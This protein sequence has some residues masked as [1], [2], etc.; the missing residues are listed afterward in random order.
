M[1]RNANVSPTDPAVNGNA[2]NPGDPAESDHVSEADLSFNPAELEAAATGPD[3]F[4]PASL[5]LPRISTL[6]WAFA[7]P[8]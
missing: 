4:D 2:E 6:A 5:R 3:P 1:A 8:C 7:R